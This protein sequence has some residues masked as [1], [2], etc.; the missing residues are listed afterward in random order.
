MS[1]TKEFSIE[2]GRVNDE[3]GPTSGVH[4]GSARTSQKLDVRLI[5]GESL[6]SVLFLVAHSLTIQKEVP[7]V[8]AC[9][10]IWHDSS[11]LMDWNQLDSWLCFPKRWPYNPHLGNTPGWFRNSLHGSFTWRTSFNVGQ[12][13]YSQLQPTAL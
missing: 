4:S 9:S 7:V 13:P 2:Q 1:D 6:I 8:E 12:K 3:T 10:R 11:V 5:P